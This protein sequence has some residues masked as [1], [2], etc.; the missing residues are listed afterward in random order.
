VEIAYHGWNHGFPRTGNQPY[1]YEFASFSCVEQ[2]IK[3]T[4]R[5]LDL[6]EKVTGKRPAGGKSPGF[7]TNEIGWEVIRK[8]GFKWWADLSPAGRDIAPRSIDLVPI[9]VL[10]DAFRF[11]ASK[12]EGIMPSVSEAIGSIRRFQHSNRL[13]RRLLKS[14]SP[15]VIQEHSTYARDDGRR[16]RPNIFDDRRSLKRIF[17]MIDRENIW[18]S[19]EEI[20]REYRISLNRI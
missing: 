9:T 16:Q 5:G 3:Q 12:P 19:C 2:G 13:I 18:T 8:C 14:D 4:I 7:K 11:I 15:I 20:G 10:G 17:R 1:R 6:I